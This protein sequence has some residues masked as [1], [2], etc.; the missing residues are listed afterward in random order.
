[1]N[2]TS[3]GNSIACEYRTV[4]MTI[5][6]ALKANLP[7]AL[8]KRLAIMC[9]SIN[10]ARQWSFAFLNWMAYSNNVLVE[11]DQTT[12]TFILF[13]FLRCPERGFKLRNGELH[14]CL[15]NFGRLYPNSWSTKKI[16]F[17]FHIDFLHY[18]ARSMIT[19]IDLYFELVRTKEFIIKNHSKAQKA[20]HY[21]EL[22]RLKRLK[23]ENKSSPGDNSIIKDKKK[24]KRKELSKDIK[25]INGLLKQIAEDSA[26][27]V[28]S[29]LNSNTSILQIINWLHS[30]NDH[31]HTKSP[32]YF[33]MANGFTDEFIPLSLNCAKSLCDRGYQ[34]DKYISC[35]KSNEMEGMYCE[36][37]GFAINLTLKSLETN[38]TKSI[39]NPHDKSTFTMATK[40]NN[41]PAKNGIRFMTAL[42]PSAKSS[43]I[44]G[45]HCFVDPGLR[46]VYSAMIKHSN[47]KSKKYVAMS[48]QRYK[49]LTHVKSSQAHSNRVSSG[50]QNII[51]ELG[52]TKTFLDYLLLMNTHWKALRKVYS[53]KS[54]KQWRFRRFTLKQKLMDLMYKELC[55]SKKQ[56]ANF[57]LNDKKRQKQSTGKL[58]VQES[59]TTVFWG[60]GGKNNVRG[61]IAVPNRNFI[62]SLCL[63]TKVF[64]IHVGYNS[65]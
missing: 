61:C 32:N 19:N 9:Y 55:T 18:T 39:D 4:C 63:K 29:E 58:S 30:N 25:D 52:I 17:L 51:S 40:I 11:H 15:N 36:T 33:P 37:D 35:F 46:Q 64:T 1:M 20:I 23:S 60:N 65:R 3:D 45:N 2:S 50:I 44:T 59:N 56:V 62:Y 43:L 41:L 47:N 53:Q 6:K 10:N 21:P 54:F 38:S 8:K 24:V 26:T 49:H 16:S 7:R 22:N 57:Y 31:L 42:N 5:K 34:W 13:F 14:E 27:K 48:S 12:L 28:Q